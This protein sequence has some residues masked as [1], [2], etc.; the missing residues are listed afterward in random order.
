MHTRA[1]TRAPS[2]ARRLIVALGFVLCLAYIGREGARGGEPAPSSVAARFAGIHFR[3]VSHEIG[4]DFR[5][6]ATRVDPRVAHIQAH[7][8]G[9][10]AAVAVVDADADGWPDLYAVTSAHGRPN[11]LFHNKGDGTFEEVAAAAGLADLNREGVGCSMGSVWGDYDN[12][13]LEDVLVYKWGQSQLFHN[14]GGLRF[15]DVTPRS[16]L[17]RWMNCNAA[18]WLDYDRD[19]RL[20]LYLAGYFDESV[21]LWNLKTTR[22]MHD[23]FEFAHNGG[24]NYLFHNNGDGT[25]EDVTEKVGAQ[26]RRWTYGIVAADFDGDGWQDIYLANDY[27]T[28]ELFLNRGGQRFERASDIGLDGESKSGMCVALGDVLNDGRLSVY[29]TNIS[30][31]GYLFQGNNL[32]LDRLADGGP[33][34]QVAE[35]PVADCGWAWGAQF[36]DLDNDGRQDLV[37]VNGFISASRDRDYWYQMSKIGIGAGGLVEDAQNWPAIED[38]SLSGYERTRVLFSAGTRGARFVEGGRE[39]GLDDDHDGRAVALFDLDRD[40]D[41]DVVIANQ[42]GPLLVYRNESTR[43]EHW[44]EI[45][46]VTT[47][48]NRSA[49]G[50]EVTLEFAGERQVQVVTAACGFASQNDR[51]MHFGLGPEPGPLRATVRWPSGVEQKVGDLKA[52]ELN[53]I[54]EAEE[55]ER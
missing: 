22:I 8:T 7:L 28:E 21:D 5:H 44:I 24:E 11:A 35:G 31:R 34:L 55:P 48:S 20:D 54:V 37:V 43:P 25:F 47:A 36:G 16:G 19:G 14:L 46:L 6:E 53:R 1:P 29:V 49:F 30:R 45:D 13:G 10:G 2:R 3:E 32:R 41:L 18:T 42:K 26:T 9:V 39:V 12:D 40:G 17:E 50:T 51:R 52:D 23:S 38:R 33:M 4:V 15:E 27:G